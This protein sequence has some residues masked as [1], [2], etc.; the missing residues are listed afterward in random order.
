MQLFCISFIFAIFSWIC[1]LLLLTLSVDSCLPSCSCRASVMR[2]WRNNASRV[3]P[4]KKSKLI[5]GKLLELSLKPPFGVGPFLFFPEALSNDC[6]SIVPKS[7]ATFTL[8]MSEAFWLR[9]MKATAPPGHCN[10]IEATNNG[11]AC[12]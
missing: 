12:R 8:L 3:T 10:A 5:T 4:I 9:D 7:G 11:S 6:L 1:I 2:R